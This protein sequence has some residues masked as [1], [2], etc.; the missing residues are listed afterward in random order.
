MEVNEVKEKKS[1]I[2]V[3]IDS[4]FCEAKIRKLIYDEESNHQKME[5]TSLK[6]LQKAYLEM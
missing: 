2:N 4:I 3:D 6:L 1:S 5:K